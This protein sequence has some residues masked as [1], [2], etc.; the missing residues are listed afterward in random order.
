LVITVFVLRGYRRQRDAQAERRPGV[1][2]LQAAPVAS[3]DQRNR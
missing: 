2:K 3:G 1:L